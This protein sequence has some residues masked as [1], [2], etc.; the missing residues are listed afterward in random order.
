MLCAV[1]VAPGVDENIWPGKQKFYT[2]TQRNISHILR[3]NSSIN[4]KVDL[5]FTLYISN[6]WCVI[7]LTGD[8]ADCELC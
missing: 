2:W 6:V 7:L 3:F 5:N 8:A 1:L 4:I